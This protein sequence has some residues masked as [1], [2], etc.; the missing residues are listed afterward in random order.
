MR[1]TER[2]HIYFLYCFSTVSVA[3]DLFFVRECIC[4]RDN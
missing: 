4:A 3:A 2:V 1:E